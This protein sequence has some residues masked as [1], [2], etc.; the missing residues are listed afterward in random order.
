MQITHTEL[1]ST[2]THPL[3]PGGENIPVTKDNRRGSYK[4]L[5]Q[6]FTLPYTDL[7][8]A[9]S[10]PSPLQIPFLHWLDSKCCIQA[11]M[12]YSHLW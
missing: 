2:V 9:L 8:M 11:D 12:Q 4:F 1:G 10:L 7:N 3:K 6:V 5:L